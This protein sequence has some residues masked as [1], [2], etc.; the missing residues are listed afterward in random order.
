ME[1]EGRSLQGWGEDP[2][3]RGN[4]GFISP[5]TLDT[6]PMEF[7]RI[8][9]AGF[10]VAQTMTHVPNYKVRPEVLSQVASQLESCAMVLKEAGVDLIAQTGV[11]ISFVDEGG[12]TS[13]RNLHARI[14][15]A[16]GLPM[17]MM[18]LAV[19]NAL[20]KM[21]CGSVAV[22]CT[23]VPE[24][25]AQRYTQFLE[26]AGIKVLAMENFVSQ[27]LFASQ[28][29]AEKARRYFPMSYTYKTARIVAAHAP[30]ADCI[31]VSGGIYS[32]DLLEPL[33]RDLNKPVISSVAA[34]FW[35]IFVRLG[36]GE[37]IRG[38]G[39]LLAS[40]DRDGPV[41]AGS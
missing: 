17:V 12:L 5:P 30:T 7:L 14:E 2:G 18:G 32:M 6:G 38:R 4:V 31:L 16:T 22:S 1:Q 15:K 39:S 3:W 33:E 27:G 20:K 41:L 34:E 19:I 23:Y 10:A 25:V 9:P 11:P 21:G 24:E 40:L 13:G 37:P 29:E 36:V 8:A 35:E 28:E 26:D